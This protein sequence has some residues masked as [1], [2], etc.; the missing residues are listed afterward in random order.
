MQSLV[1]LHAAQPCLG[2]IGEAHAPLVQGAV[3]VLQQIHETSVVEGLI[4]KAEQV[5]DPALRS[6]IYGGLA[7]LYHKEADWDGTWW[8]TRPDTTGPYYK[9]V[10]W[11]G[12][13]RIGATL[14]SALGNADPSTVRSLVSEIQR[15][16]VTAPEVTQRVNEIARTDPQVKAMVIE[17]LTTRRAL[18]GDE[19][20]MLRGVATSADEPAATRAKAIRALQ[21]SADAGNDTAMAVVVQ[22]LA[23]VVT[24]E[25]P[26]AQLA[27][28]L[29]EFIRDTGH[30]GHVEQ[31]A[32]LAET[33]DSGA[34]R[35]LGYAVLLNLSTSR[36]VK[37]PKRH[38][39][40]GYVENGWAKPQ[41]AIALLRAIGLTKNKEYAQ[42]VLALK[43]DP[44]PA[45]AQTAEEVASLIG[46]GNK[47]GGTLIEE[48]S[49][50]SVVA[51]A[52]KDKGDAR[53]GAELFQRQGCV[54]C[55]TTST[56]EPPKGPMLA[57]ITGR[58]SRAEL[59]ESILK[60]SAKIAQGFE[61][62]WFKTQENGDVLEGFVTRE[63]G[64]DLELRNAAGN[65]MTLRKADIKQ[66]GK[67]D[68]S[69]MPEGLVAKLTPHDLASILAFL[70][71]LGSG[72]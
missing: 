54:A 44:R 27:A 60:P 71:S 67:R 36:L 34:K 22:A 59:C 35:E 15:N 37:A 33:G 20:Q 3:R 55:H 11:E 62:Q 9:P 70:E 21:R 17:S 51:A 30:A 5:K 66:R 19:V 41:T 68:T 12:T 57:G 7:R 14:A 23:G 39:A 28:A 1:A 53:L 48:M 29:N 24:S 52:V 64:D 8:G 47:A 4:A 40:E 26:D 72:K 6:Q 45:V 58:Y 61:T 50:E 16:G 13:S 69:V 32:K 2:V 56:S 38:A 42:K 25:K 43:S 31:I 63:S 18:S 10:E 46:A 49:Y 65:V